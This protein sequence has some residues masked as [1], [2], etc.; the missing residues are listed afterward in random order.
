MPHAPIS[1]LQKYMGKK[2]DICFFLAIRYD[3][4]SIMK[5]IFGLGNP[6][7][8]YAVTR[9][10]CGFLTLEQ[11]AE[12]LGVSFDKKI[13]DNLVA[14]TIFEGEKLLL[15]K[16]QLYMN[17]SGF[18]LARLC[19]YY[20]VDYSDILVVL[21]DLSLPPTALRFRR[22]GSDGGHNGM[23]SIIEQTGTKNINRLKIGIGEALF[24]TVDH[25]I[26]QFAPEDMPAFAKVFSVA[27]KA[28]LYW[29][30][31]GIDAAMNKYNCLEPILIQGSSDDS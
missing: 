12:Q 24:N 15:A 26:G 4:I 11:L 29:A 1:L 8:R 5:I 9:H 28:A 27:S 2:C 14:S 30:K 20:K 18:P 21:D 25:V 7:L 6:G 22:G 16:P 19:H 10:N 23:K 17:L 3:K 31:E 13:E